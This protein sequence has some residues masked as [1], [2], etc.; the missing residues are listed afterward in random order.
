MKRVRY[1]KTTDGLLSSAIQLKDKT[2][3]ARINSDFR[4]QIVELTNAEIASD[5]ARNLPEAKRVVKN[6]LKRLGVVFL[7]EV[8]TRKAK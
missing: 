7:D 8:R 4:V 2:V 6:L 5:N 3:F 1:T